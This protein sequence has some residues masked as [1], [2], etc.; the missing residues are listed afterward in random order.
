ML[1]EFSVNKNKN[2]YKIQVIF[3]ITQSGKGGM[4]IETQKKHEGSL[5]WLVHLNHYQINW[6]VQQE[7]P[8]LA[9][10]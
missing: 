7:A 2:Q 8:I 10:T 1:M 4:A 3:F 6:V 9:G 5:P